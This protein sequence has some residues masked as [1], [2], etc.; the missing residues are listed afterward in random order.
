[1]LFTYHA[2]DQDGH[3][4]DGTIDALSQDVAV[5]ALQR[6]NLIVS[7]IESAEKRSLLN[8]DIA[9]FSRV[10]TKDIVILSRQIAILFGAQISALRAFRLLA[11]DVDNK[12]LSTILATIADDL[13]GGSPISTALARHPDVFSEFYVNMVRSGEESGKLAETLNYLADYIDRS[14]D[15]VSKI[16]NALIYPAFVIGVFFIIMWLMLTLVIP[17]ITVILV[18]SGQEV[19]IYTKIIIALSDFLVNYGLFLFIAIVGGIIYLWRLSKTE[20]MRLIFDNIKLS[21]PYIGN[22][23]RKLYLERIADTLSTMLLSG[24]SVVKALEITVSVVDNAGYK[25]LLKEVGKDVVG[26]SSISSALA[27]HPEIPN[28]MVTMTKVGEETG[29]LGSILPML[30]K[31]YNREM[32]NA[33]DVLV[34][35]IEPIMI[36][37]LGLGV[38]VLLAAVLVP[39]YNLAGGVG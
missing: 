39:I 8:M 9:F 31:F 23:Y 1:M 14:H 32:R 25:I 28:I 37:A 27:K 12:K 35:L 29:E 15:I 10:K 13:Q 34:S 3:K 22:L 16:E 17:K 18:E 36:V 11:A 20:S 38:G 6:R 5:V 30:A 4:R 26:G 24:I 33:V 2:I 7:F 21:I 19:P